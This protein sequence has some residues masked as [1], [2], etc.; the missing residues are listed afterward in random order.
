MEPLDPPKNV[1]V[2]GFSKRR[3]SSILKAPRKSTRFPD[4]EQQ[5]NV[6]ACAKPLEKRSSRR[7][8]FA[9]ANDVLLFSKDAKNA[10]P[11]HTPSQELVTAAT[12]TTQNRIQVAVAEDG[13]QQIL[14]M[15]NLLKAPL[16]TSQQRDKVNF[17]TVD[18][19]G[20]KTIMFSTDDAFMD[21][22]HSHTINIAN[23]AEILGDISLQNYDILPTVKEKDGMFIVGDGLTDMTLSHT[24][25][26]TDGFLS[27]RRNMDVSGEKRNSLASMPCLDPRFENFLSSLSKPSGPSTIAMITRMTPSVETS[28]EETSGSLAQ[29]KTQRTDVDKENQAPTCV[30]AVLEKSLDNSRKIRESSYG[31]ALCPKD[32]ISMD[33]TEAQTGC[34]QP[35]GPSSNCVSARMTSTAA[36][37]SAETTNTNSSPFQL[38]TPRADVEYQLLSTIFPEDDANMDMTEVQTGCITGTTGCDDPFQF[39][40]PTQDMYP[41]CGHLK[42]ADITPVL[43]SSEA[44]GSPTHKGMKTSLKPSFKAKAQRHQKLDTEDNYREKTVG[45]TADEACMDVTQ[46]HTVHIA[47]DFNLQAHQNFDFLP[48]CGEKTLRFATNDATMDMTQCLTVDIASNLV[49][50]SGLPLKKQEGETFGP[51]KSRSS[52]AHGLNSASNSVLPPYSK[53][54]DP[55]FSVKVTRMMPTAATLSG[56][57]I[58][59]ADDLNMD[60]TEAHVGCILEGD[61]FMDMTETQTGQIIGILGTDDPL[62]CLFPTK[63]T[64]PQSGNLKKAKTTSTQQ[65]SEA[66]GPSNS[67]GIVASLKT[68][69]KTEMQIHQVESDVEF[70]CKE[71]TVRFT[72]NEACMDVTQSHTVNIATDFSMISQQK[73]DLPANG[74][75]IMRFTATDANMDVTKSHTVN[76]ATDFHPKSSHNVDF[77]PT[78]AEKTVRF[79]A[80]EAAVDVTRS[81]TVNIATDLNL[82]PYQNVDLPEN[83]E[84]TV[85][86]TAN[87]VSMDVTKSHTVNIATDLNRL[88]RQSGAILP[89]NGEKTVKF[90]T[91]EACMDVTQSHTVNIATDFKP[92]HENVDFLPT[93]GEKTVRF[94]TNDA[95]MDLTQCL[96]VNVTSNVASESILSQHV[97]PPPQNVDFPSAV[98]ERKSETSGPQRNRSSVQ[99]SDPK[100]TKSQLKTSGPSAC[101]EEEDTNA[102]FPQETIDANGFLVHLKTQ[103]PDVNDKNEAPVLVSAFTEKPVNKNMT[104]CPDVKASIDMTEAPTGY[105]LQQTCT[106]EPP[107]FPSSRQNHSSELLKKIE[108]T[109][110]P[111]KEGSSNPDDVEITKLTHSPY[112]NETETNKE[113]EPRSATCLVAKKMESPPSAADQ[114]DDALC[115]QTSRRKSLADLQSRVRRLSRLINAGPDAV[116]I[117][118]CIA[119]FPQLDTNL[120]KNSRDKTIPLPELKTEPALKM[121][122]VNTEDKVQSFTQEE[123]P[124]VSA[125][126]TPFSLKTKLMS[127][128]SVGG[129]KPKLPQRS[130]PDEAKKGSS[131]GEHIVTIYSNVAHK[132]SNFDN[133]VSDIFDEELGSYEDV[134]ETLNTRSPENISEIASP[135][136]EFNAIEPLEE[137]VFEE[138]IISTSH[139]QKRPLPEGE[140]NMEDEKRMKASPE[141][142]EMALQSGGVE[143]ETM[144]YCNNSHTASIRCEAASE[145]TIKHSL[146]ESQLE[147]YTSDAQKKLEDGSITVL[148][149]F[150]LFNI[151][152]VIHNPRQSVLPDRLLS[153]TDATSMDLLKDRHISRPKQVVYEADVLTLTEEVERLKVRMW[154]LDKP[155]KTVNRPLW[156]EMK[157]SSENQLKSFGAKLKERNNFF[158]KT[159][160]VQS[161]EMKEVLYSN[162][163]QANLEEQQKLREAIEQADK[164]IQSLDDCIRELETELAAVEENG[165]EDK[166]SLN[167]L[168]KEMKK[169]TE[170]LADND[171]Q[172]SELEMEKK[173]N[174]SKLGRLKAET[175]NLESHIDVLNMVN[176]WRFKGRRDNST[177]YTFLNET[178]YLHLAYEKPNGTDAEYG[179]ERKITHIAFKFELDDE[180]SQFHARI[181]HKLLSQYTE[182]E[183]AWV[184]KY[185]T[186]SRVPKLLHDIS[187]VV[188]HCRLLG[189]ELRLLKMWGGLQLDVLDISCVDTRVHI[190]FSSLKKLSK[191]EVVFAVSLTNYLYVLQVESFKNMTGSVTIQQIEDIVA[192]FIPARNLLTKIVK[193]IHTTLLC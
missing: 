176:E 27:T 8:S 143:C 124:S 51:P 179:S 67:T 5:E 15:E 88:S 74:E 70:D 147:D 87:E 108:V 184:E 14:G 83:G 173:Q 112:L 20:E 18:D 89:T 58:F 141:T 81:H 190:V 35:S 130:K 9:P 168:Q 26:M 152:F 171:R 12:D 32:D 6:V 146:F 148:D 120:D 114:D 24:V 126:T 84:E 53:L 68:S 189:E 80:N 52:S 139:G 69:L 78:S 177:I 47:T 142:T 59:P 185:P 42:M 46:S 63:D 162:L 150:K 103:E 191:F 28:S 181:V 72:A 182:G 132:L 116:A 56:S 172:I 188:S 110:P 175:R 82:Q 156:E 31:S 100:F 33:I 62:E 137:D 73:M 140:N 36:P 23:D 11:G 151:D 127:R 174:S 121:G 30:Y 167:S 48:T 122:L 157:H 4:Q 118:S 55:S 144:N 125:T 178:V 164:M 106:D 192:W 119:P 37:S 160:K 76:I 128:L 75:K 1:D 97:L 86:F 180:K 57:T 44:L 22:T 149:F 102:Q 17:D 161:H 131:A 135:S 38:N 19:F 39:L 129:F 43:L 54:S 113:P 145:S 154:D 77:L 134:S 109:L 61:A 155:L 138:D 66:L 91:N 34:I 123:Q 163:V 71:N 16:H 29:I 98:N 183:S 94:T 99:A 90:P 92:K 111:S 93:N 169:V 153:D 21:M 170:T 60:M 64:S 10:S 25:N 187:L 2:S 165:F 166:P 193:K 85:R 7:V 186:S 115:Y 95:I 96:T 49:S 45:F 158:R 107:Q 117:D 104:G 40:F 50:N 159:S 133:D 41:H 13:S 3:I 65:N 105:I 79:T 136:R 101:S